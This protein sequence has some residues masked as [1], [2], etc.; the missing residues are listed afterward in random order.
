M[1]VIPVPQQAARSALVSTPPPLCLPVIPL[2]SS[3]SMPLA[4][5]S[6]LD[7]SRLPR[8]RRPVS[9]SVAALSVASD[10]RRMA[11][12][13]S[14]RLTLLHHGTGKL[15]AVRNGRDC[16]SQRWIGQAPE[17]CGLSSGMHG[18]VKIARVKEGE[19]HSES[20]ILARASDSRMSDSSCRAVAVMVLP[21]PPP[22]PRRLRY[23]CTSCSP[24]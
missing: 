22:L 7:P 23:A 3:A 5:L 8:S 19:T 15:E 13:T 16:Y 14:A 24:A 11:S 20:R 12:S 4:S 1:D 9:G 18:G 10:M 6:L 17:D 21:S 2:T